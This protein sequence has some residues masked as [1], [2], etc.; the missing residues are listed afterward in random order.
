MMRFDMLDLQIVDETA[1]NRRLTSRVEWSLRRNRKIRQPYVLQH[2]NSRG[3]RGITDQVAVI[4]LVIERNLA[5]RE[6]DDFDLLD[7]TGVFVRV[8]RIDRFVREQQDI[9]AQG[10]AGGI[11]RS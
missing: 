2:G 9:V 5:G 6:V 10:Q 7:L 11:R 4:N 3:R 1:G 8:L